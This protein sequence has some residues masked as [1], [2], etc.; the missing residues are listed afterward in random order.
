MVEAVEVKVRHVGNA[1]GVILPSRIINDEK[2]RV[3]ESVMVSVI[4]KSNGSLRDLLGIAR[5][6]KSFK[7][8][9]GGRN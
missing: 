3:G 1:L 5:G 9:H 4:K 6:A 8:E 2:I 7:R